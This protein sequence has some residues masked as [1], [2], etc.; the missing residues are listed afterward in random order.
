MVR[1]QASR[2]RKVIDCGANSIQIGLSL[3]KAIVFSMAAQWTTLQGTSHTLIGV[4]CYTGGLKY[5]K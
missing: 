2:L 3:L 4:F 5:N 1:R